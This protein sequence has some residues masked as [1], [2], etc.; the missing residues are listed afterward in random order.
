MRR[1]LVFEATRKAPGNARRAVRAT[2]ARAGH[3]EVAD[4][5]EL[6][7]SEL[8]TNAVRHADD[9]VVRV[10]VQ[11]DGVVRVAVTDGSQALPVLRDSGEL[12]TEGRGM[13]LVNRMAQ[14]WGVEVRGRGGKVVWFELSA[15]R[16]AAAARRARTAVRAVTAAATSLV[17][18]ARKAGGAASG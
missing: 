11:S 17:T 8:V 2:L 18:R 15:R 16:A 3:E 13:A 9:D 4:T 12:D 10:D 6:L 5:A 7:T 14:R 1:Q